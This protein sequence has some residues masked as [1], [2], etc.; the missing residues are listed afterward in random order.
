[1]L[2]ESAGLAAEEGKALIALSLDLEMSRNFPTWDQTHWDYE[3]G[4]LDAPTKR[5]AV[6]AARRVQA[7]GGRLHFFV[8]GQVFEQEQVDW[9][10]EIARA[11]HPIGNHTYDHVN[12]KTTRLRDIQYR[13]QRAPWLIEGKRAHEVIRENIR[14]CSAALKAR[15][16]VESNGFRTPGGFAD[17]LGDR[18]DVQRLLLDLGFRWVSSLYPSHPLGKPG[19]ELAAA[20]YEGIVKAQE[21]AQPFVYP[22]GLVEVPMS[23]VSDIV[24]FRSGRWRLE[25]FLRAL[26]LA[27]E[28]AIEHRAVFDFLGHPSCLCVTD[29][30]FRAVEL[31]CALVKKAGNRAALVDLGTVAERGRLRGVRPAR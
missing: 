15:V 22:G 27:V 16:G 7:H 19:E 9:L 28:W 5:Y 17:G 1:V 24:A 2:R 12:V 10:R 4:N 29:P 13:F 8:V 20:V 14:L 6:E 11:G 25:W 30:E 21:A 31:I 23:P 18:P 26:R 3:K